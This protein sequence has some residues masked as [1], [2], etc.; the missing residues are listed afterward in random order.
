[1]SNRVMQVIE[2]C[3]QLAVLAYAPLKLLLHAKATWTSSA[4]AELVMT[5]MLPVLSAVNLVSLAY[6]FALRGPR[7][8]LYLTCGPLFYTCSMH[9]L[10]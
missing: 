10:G 1:M 8:V 5:L 2:L 9:M 7:E 6:D 4:S 3:V